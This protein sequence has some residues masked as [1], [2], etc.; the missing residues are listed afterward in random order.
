MQERGA[1]PRRGRGD[2]GGWNPGPS[3]AN[4]RFWQVLAV[5]A[6]IVATAG[7]TTV[8]V[9]N[10]DDGGPAEPTAAATDDSTDGPIPVSHSYPELEALLPTAVSGI[11]L[12]IESWSGDVVFGTDPWS[13]SF[14]A[15]LATVGRTPADVQVAQAY[16]PAGSIESGAA[17]YRVEGI[18]AVG[19]RDAM[20]AAWKEQYPDLV[21]SDITLGGRSVTKGLF[22]SDVPD[23]YW[24]ISGDVVFDVETSG[25]ALAT[26]V[27]AALPEPG[28]SSSPS[29]APSGSPAATPSPS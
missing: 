23:S 2:G 8:V 11:A 1:R 27:L 25:E 17:A 26:T 4:L 18:S 19:L 7:W 12:T 3:G 28:P 16:D 24:Y 13:Q 15:Y 5:V 14:T 9:M 6:I 20:I 21:V 22:G 29:G 10:L